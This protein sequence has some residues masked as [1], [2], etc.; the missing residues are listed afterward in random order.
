M[1]IA[2]AGLKIPVIWHVHDLLPRHPLSTTIRFV[3]IAFP[4]THVVAVSHAVAR[5]FCGSLL[6]WFSRRPQITTIHNAVDIEKFQPHPWKRAGKRLSLGFS[7][8]EPIVGIVGQLTARKGQLETIEAFAQ[9]AQSFP[10]AKLVII[11][12]ALFNRD[13]EYA[14]TLHETARCLGIADRVL[15]LGQREDIRELTRAF[16]LAIVNSQA[17][18]FGLTV[19]EAMASGTPVLAT[20]VDGI[21]EIVEHGKTGWLVTSG[22]GEQLAGAIELL[23]ADRNLRAQLSTSALASVRSRF[24]ADRFITDLERLYRSICLPLASRQAQPRKLEVKLSAD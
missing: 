15:F 2:T 9:A 5:R 14:D 21:R 10:D 12:E 3:A 24:A 18:P 4:Q 8:Y 17:E 11:G 7:D 13:S 16:D 1:S 23:L 6:R 20:A 19:V 22:D